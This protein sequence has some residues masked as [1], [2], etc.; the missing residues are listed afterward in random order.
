M[1]QIVW[2]GSSSIRTVRTFVPEPGIPGILGVRVTKQLMKDY[3]YDCKIDG[4]DNKITVEKG[5]WCVTLRFMECLN[6]ENNEY[7]VPVK[8]KEIKVPLTNIYFPENQG[9]NSERFSIKYTIRSEE[10]M[11]QTV[12]YYTI[13]KSSI[14]TLRSN[15]NIDLE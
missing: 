1:Q 15:L 7:K 4:P 12:N 8:T 11:R 9:S 3:V 2:I 10:I 14:D 6:K 5:I 13:C